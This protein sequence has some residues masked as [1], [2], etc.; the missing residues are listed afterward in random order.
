MQWLK[1]T[2]EWG[3]S[4]HRREKQELEREGMNGEDEKKEEGRNKF[5]E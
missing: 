5:Y 1:S 2:P 3:R 4:H